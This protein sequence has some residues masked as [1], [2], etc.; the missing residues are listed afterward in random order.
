MYSLHFA[1]NKLSLVQ[2]PSNVPGALIFIMSGFDSEG[3]GSPDLDPDISSSAF[4][5]PLAEKGILG[6]TNEVV[7]NSGATKVTG[8]GCKV[9]SFDSRDKVAITSADFSSSC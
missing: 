7:A 9:L 8:L 2:S 1:K 3:R 4:F 6:G 5:F